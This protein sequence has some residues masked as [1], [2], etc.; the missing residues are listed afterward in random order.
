VGTD[1]G[2]L[3]EGD[4]ELGQIR[5][6]LQ[7]ALESQG[8]VLLVEGPAGI[9]KTAMLMAARDAG[10]GQGFRV[11]RARGAQLE[12]EYAFGVVRQLVEPLLAE[13]PSVERALLMDGPAGLAARLLG[14]PS[15]PDQLRQPAPKVR[16][17]PGGGYPGA[18]ARATADHGITNS[19]QM[20][21]LSEEHPPCLRPRST[22]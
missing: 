9:G 19:S 12:R 15:E 16:A 17:C 18:N 14:I 5:G 6:R 2:P 8:G 4:R 20:S 11:L 1:E 13:T 10:K 21:H 22:A 7:R 3:L